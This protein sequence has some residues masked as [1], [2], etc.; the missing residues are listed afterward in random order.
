M[1]SIE[2]MGWEQTFEFGLAVQEEA[3]SPAAEKPN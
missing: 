2:P 1:R 3:D